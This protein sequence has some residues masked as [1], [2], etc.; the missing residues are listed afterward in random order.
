MSDA[1][2]DRIIWRIENGMSVEAAYRQAAIFVA[3]A[4]IRRVREGSSR[5]EAW[6]ALREELNCTDLPL[7]PMW[8]FNPRKIYMILSGGRVAGVPDAKCVAQRLRK[9]LKPTRKDIEEA[10]KAC[11]K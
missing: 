9:K 7:L 4:A 10:F 3:R 1:I 11:M 5:E 2:R 6:N 8:D